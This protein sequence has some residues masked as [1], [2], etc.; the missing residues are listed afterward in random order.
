MTC[1][2]KKSIYRL[3]NIYSTKWILTTSQ[4]STLQLLEKIRVQDNRG[5]SCLQQISP[6]YLHT[7]KSILRYNLMFPENKGFK[8][9]LSSLLIYL[10]QPTSKQASKKEWYSDDNLNLCILLAPYSNIPRWLN[11]HRTT[12]ATLEIRKGSHPTPEILS[13]HKDI[14]RW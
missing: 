3:S 8:H 5:T 1:A 7:L 13:F 12:Q 10:N 11:Q 4:I 14:L 6:I 9:F 2:K